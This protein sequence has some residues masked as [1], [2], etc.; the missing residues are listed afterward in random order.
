[1]EASRTAFVLVVEVRPYLQVLVDL[2]DAVSLAAS[3][4]GHSES[5]YGQQHLS[6]VEKLMVLLRL[7]STKPNVVSGSTSFERL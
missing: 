1:M 2:E 4:L 5:F 6:L 7:S 3:S